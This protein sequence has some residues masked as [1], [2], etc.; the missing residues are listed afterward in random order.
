[1]A[2]V[3]RRRRNA[4]DSGRRRSGKKGKRVLVGG[5]LLVLAARGCAT[6]SEASLPS[7]VAPDRIRVVTRSGHRRVLSGA[8][9]EGD[10][11]LV[12]VP[13]GGAQE[14]RFGVE[15]IA[16]L[17]ARVANPGGTATIA[18][19]LVLVGGLV[20]LLVSVPGT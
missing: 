10:S 5:A 16:R 6:W 7:G 2:M 9:M 3:H 14:V 8:R 18:G 17:E 15:E 4:G 11:V 1:M 20:L 13:E 19:A 12:G